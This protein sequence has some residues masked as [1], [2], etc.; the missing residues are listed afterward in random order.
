MN[1]REIIRKSAQTSNAWFLIL[2]LMLLI[3]YLIYRDFPEGRVLFL[4]LMVGVFSCS[5]SYQD[6]C[7][8]KEIVRLEEKIEEL[9]KRIP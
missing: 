2:P 7:L 5:S 8:A 9:E 3:N 6:R 4:F 1:N